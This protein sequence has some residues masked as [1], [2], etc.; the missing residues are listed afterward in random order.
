MGNYNVIM[1]TNLVAIGNSRGVRIPKLMLIESG[2]GNV[3]ELRTKK[4][5]IKIIAVKRSKVVNKDTLILSQR[6]LGTDWD[7]P[8][9]DEAWASLQ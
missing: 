3:V 7:R 5:E 1:I 6:S 2:L 8:E 4:G 9:E